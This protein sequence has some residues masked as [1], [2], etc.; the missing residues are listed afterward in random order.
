MRI[1]TKPFNIY[2]MHYISSKKSSSNHFD[3]IETTNTWQPYLYTQQLHTPFGYLKQNPKLIF[4][5][6]TFLFHLD[7]YYF[8]VI[9]FFFKKKWERLQFLEH[10][11]Q[12]LSL[13]SFLLLKCLYQ[14]WWT[15]AQSIK[16][17]LGLSFQ[18]PLSANCFPA[19]QAFFFVPLSSQ[20]TQTKSHLHP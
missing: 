2:T 4:I 19:S 9:H 8:L 15:S 10:T 6:T 18:A 17:H 1:I 12:L 3:F 20:P 16:R 11:W 7:L 5:S 13:V 14:A